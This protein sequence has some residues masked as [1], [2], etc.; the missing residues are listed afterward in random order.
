MTASGKEPARLSGGLFATQ[1]QEHR[2]LDLTHLPFMSSD[3][4]KRA[5]PAL[6]SEQTV[7]IVRTASRLRCTPRCRW[8]DAS[9]LPEP[10]PIRAGRHS[11]HP[12]YGIT[13]AL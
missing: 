4:K 1:P 8:Q 3:A 10:R 12:H 6:R 9:P 11:L 2:A 7:R 5:S 13:D